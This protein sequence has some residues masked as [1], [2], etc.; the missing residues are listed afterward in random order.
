MRWNQEAYDAEAGSYAPND[1]GQ[2]HASLSPFR[3]RVESD[4]D[5]DGA[6][7][8]AEPL[9]ARRS[10]LAPPVSPPNP[11]A[12]PTQRDL[13][14]HRLEASRP[15]PPP[16]AAPASS[17]RAASD[18]AVPT[19]E[20]PSPTTAS[21]AAE[22]PERRPAWLNYAAFVAALLVAVALGLWLTRQPETP[23]ATPSRAEVPVAPRVEPAPRPAEALTAPRR[24]APAAIATLERPQPPAPVDAAS[25]REAAQG[26]PDVAVRPS[27]AS[28]KVSAPAKP[29]PAPRKTNPPPTSRESIF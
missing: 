21:I 15:P 23:P 16:A 26:Q 22:E 2:I 8:R 13:P 25:A 18:S 17:P 6:P 27:A 28:N 10:E 12:V 20:G 5:F 4:L 29:A 1:D 11:S 14:L 9:A 24:E 19:S 3:E 7:T